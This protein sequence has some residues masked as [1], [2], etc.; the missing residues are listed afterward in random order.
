MLF[1]KKK[2]H[3]FSSFFNL[4]YLAYLK[5]VV[6]TKLKIKYTFI[7]FSSFWPKKFNLKPDSG[8][9]ISIN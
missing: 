3:I 4:K 8:L 2:N 9:I 6:I 1:S 5:Y 7:S